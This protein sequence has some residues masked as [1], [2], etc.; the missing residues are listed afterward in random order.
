MCVILYLQSTYR[1]SLPHAL[2]Q[3]PRTFH[4]GIKGTFMNL[5]THNKYFRNIGYNTDSSVT[6]PVSNS[7]GDSGGE[8]GGDSSVYMQ[9]HSSVNQYRVEQLVKSCK[10]VTSVM[11]LLRYKGEFFL[12]TLYLYIYWRIEYLTDRICACNCSWLL[13][14]KKQ[15]ATALQQFHART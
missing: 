11:D 13:F 6:W 15:K 9:G 12:R 8:S 10:H 1:F 4:N 7:G 2:L 14:H 3:V 5:E